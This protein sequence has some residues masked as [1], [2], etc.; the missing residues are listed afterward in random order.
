MSTETLMGLYE[1]QLRQIYTAECG[2]AQLHPRMATAAEC[3]QLREAMDTQFLKGLQ[4]AAA[5]R[6]IFDSLSLVR[7]GRP[8]EGMAGLLNEAA[9]A[10]EQ[11]IE[12]EACDAVLVAVASRICH[13]MWAAY[14]TASA[15]ALALGRF[16]DGSR[17]RQIVKCEADAEK[18]LGRL[19]LLA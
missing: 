1:H 10:I 7:F 4:N 6:C 11:Y 16:E 12:G 8:C 17:L 5:L 9:E 14:T 2:L 19:A 13:Y 15:Y 18:T 3:L